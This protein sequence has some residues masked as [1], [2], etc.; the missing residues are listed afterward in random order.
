RRSLPRPRRSVNFGAV[1]WSRCAGWWPA[2]L[3]VPL[4][5]ALYLPGLFALPP[6]DRD[7][8]RYAQAAR[9][10][11]ESGDFT[12]PHL[13]EEPRLIKP[14][15]AYWLQVA[16]L[17]L[18][19]PHPGAPIGAHRLPS[20]LGAFAA[21]F[22]TYAI[23]RRWFAPRVACLGAAWLAASALL[24]VEAHLATTDAV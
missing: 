21:V 22:G 23:G 1:R 8:A 15:G 9:Q 16:A 6:I 17:R 20:V 13:Q 2:T 11:V 7:E 3:L 12:V 19:D 10:M 5:A 24:V 18:A 14:I 4:C